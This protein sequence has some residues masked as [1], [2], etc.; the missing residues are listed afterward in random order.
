[1]RSNLPGSTALAVDSPELIG[2][3]DDR[4]GQRATISAT[5]PPPS[6]PWCSAPPD[7]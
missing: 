2:G 7:T 6:G 4:L 5:G 1:L 3:G